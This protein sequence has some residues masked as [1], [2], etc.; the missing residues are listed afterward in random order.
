M[1]A[2]DTI[3]LSVT[4]ENG[5]FKIAAKDVEQALG[6][7]GAGVSSASKQVVAG[8]QKM[9][10]SFGSLTT[11]VKGFIGLQIVQTLFGIGKAALQGAAELEKNK[12]AFETMLGSGKKAATL[13]DDIQTMAAKTPLETESIVNSAKQLIAFGESA[14]RKSVV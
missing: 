3:Q 8:N 5:Q 9:G 12:I 13:M 1:A 11:L 6:K 14:D 7:M 2:S 4:L 10:S